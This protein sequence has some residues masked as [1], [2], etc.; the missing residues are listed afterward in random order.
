MRKNG[1][2]KGGLSI[3]RIE[4][5]FF[6]VMLVVTNATEY[7]SPFVFLTANNETTENRVTGNDGQNLTM[8]WKLNNISNADWPY[9]ENL[10]DVYNNLLITRVNEIWAFWCPPGANAYMQGVFSLKKN[11]ETMHKKIKNMNSE[12]VVDVFSVDKLREIGCH[13]L[14]RA[15]WYK[16]DPGKVNEFDKQL[17]SEEGGEQKKPSAQQLPVLFSPSANVLEAEVTL[18]MIGYGTMWFVSNIGAT[19]FHFDPHG[20]SHETEVDMDSR[21]VYFCPPGAHRDVRTLMLNDSPHCPSTIDDD[22]NKGVK[23]ADVTI[24]IPHVV[25]YSHEV[26]VCYM[27]DVMMHCYENF[28]GNKDACGPCPVVVYPKKINKTT[29]ESWNPEN[30][31]FSPP[32]EMNLMSIF[33][34]IIG[35]K[36]MDKKP[37]HDVGKMTKFGEGARTNNEVYHDYKW[38]GVHNYPIRNCYMERGTVSVKG[39]YFDDFETQWGDIRVSEALKGEARLGVHR[40]SGYFKKFKQEDMCRYIAQITIKNVKVR[41]IPIRS[42]ERGFKQAVPEDAKFTI[43]V[44]SEKLTSIFG[45]FDSQK[46][47]NEADLPSCL[48]GTKGEFYHMSGDRLMLVRNKRDPP[49]VLESEELVF[50][51]G[52]SE[53][54][55]AS[56]AAD[57]DLTTYREINKKKARFYIKKRPDGKVVPKAKF[58]PRILNFFKDPKTLGAVNSIEKKEDIKNNF[59]AIDGENI[60]TKPNEQLTF[61][62]AELQRIINHNAAV[63]DQ[64]RCLAK[65]TEHDRRKLNAILF[66]SQEASRIVG[67]RVKVI[68]PG[69]DFMRIAPCQPVDYELVENLR[70]TNAANLDS[71]YIYRVF[72][73]IDGHKKFTKEDINGTS[74]VNGSLNIMYLHHD[75]FNESFGV[76]TKY[77]KTYADLFALSGINLTKVSSACFLRPLLVFQDPSNPRIK[78]VA[79]LDPQYNAQIQL[80]DIG[81]CLD[82]QIVSIEETVAV[83]LKGILTGLIDRN[84][85]RDH[86][87]MKE[88]RDRASLEEK[89]EAKLKE[90]FKASMRTANLNDADDEEDDQPSL[91]PILLEG[92]ESKSRVTVSIDE[93]REHVGLSHGGSVYAITDTG[94]GK[95]DLLRLMTRIIVA[96]DTYSHDRAANVPDMFFNL[97]DDQSYD[98]FRRIQRVE[99]RSFHELMLDMVRRTDVEDLSYIGNSKLDG[100]LKIPNDTA[101]GSDWNRAAR[102]MNGA[103]FDGG[104]LH[105]ITGNADKLFHTLIDD[106][107]YALSTAGGLVKGGVEQVG[108]LAGKTVHNVLGGLFGGIF[109]KIMIVLGALVGVTLFVFV[110]FK[111]LSVEQA[112]RTER[113]NQQRLIDEINKQSPTEV[114]QTMHEKSYEDSE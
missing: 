23:I 39:P 12:T 77:P 68:G 16:I 94:Q 31:C 48:K 70:L 106:G 76:E 13:P 5:F 112:K 36:N 69:G 91:R 108:D 100:G 15:A 85:F 66:P 51:S 50:G 61:M 57:H 111:C 92:E 44:T 98:M 38:W 114:S 28:L 46:I 73:P 53:R 45:T 83:Y 41:E 113:Q 4:N 2:L 109:G 29:C 26:R 42:E 11:L 17:D 75:L 71:R 96:E 25:F 19:P 9:E 43:Q 6:L 101:D 74:A 10:L 47:T 62:A 102:D 40:Y 58:I 95:S 20:W 59:D 24:Y 52:Y 81:R 105:D 97:F 35:G 67:R 8:K 1:V 87:K 55:S 60:V 79:Q 110:L 14:N 7:P 21:R 27:K 80:R 54:I 72:P 78:I 90:R 86:K 65:K 56:E 63:E 99:E 34:A 49:V 18:P 32:P 33:Q 64:T 107:A 103:V 88:I 82:V 89:H 22:Y 104:F 30:H 3:G 37:N 93:I 84:I